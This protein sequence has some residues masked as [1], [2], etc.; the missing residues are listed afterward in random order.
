MAEE[1]NA[2][3]E[4]TGDET[5]ASDIAEN[6]EADD[7]LFK[8]DKMFPEGDEKEEDEESADKEKTTLLNQK[9]HW[10]EKAS[11]LEGKLKDA[12]KKLDDATTALKQS[13]KGEDSPEA[14]KEKSARDLVKQ[15]AREAMAEVKATEE[16]KLEKATDEFEDSLAFVLEEHDDVS[17]EELLKI[18]EKYE[19]EPGTAYKIFKD[20]QK[21]G[22]SKPRLP[23]PK[24]GGETVETEEKDEKNKK[25]KTW[26]DVARESLEMLRKSKR[27]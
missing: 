18:C 6:E 7:P 4:K 20:T 19:V 9:K 23:Q 15:L 17:E 2:P 11:K 13:D 5:E 16:A 21:G 14:R 22:K 3:V 1:K 24:R 25:P 12:L 10:R 8:E 27:S 26:T